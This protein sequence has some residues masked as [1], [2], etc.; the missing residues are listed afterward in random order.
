MPHFTRAFPKFYF[1]ART[2]L[3]VGVYLLQAALMELRFNQDDHHCRRML[4][5][6]F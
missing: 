6:D 4:S 2:L 1:S 5:C 3:S